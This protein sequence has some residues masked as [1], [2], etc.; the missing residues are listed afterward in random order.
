MPDG[1]AETINDA[2]MNF[3]EEKYIDCGTQP[4]GL[5]SDGTAFMMGHDSGVG[6]RSQ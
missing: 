5:R 3:M 2:L 1:E 4:V 6:V